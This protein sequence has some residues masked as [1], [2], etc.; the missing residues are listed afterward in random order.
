MKKKPVILIICN[1]YLPGYK[2]GGGMRTIVNTVERLKDKFDFRIIT[3]NCD[4]DG[5]PYRNIKE[6]DWNRIGGAQVFYLPQKSA[7][8]SKI[9]ELINEVQP[10][11]VYLNSVFS[12]LTIKTLL[13]RKLSL[14]PPVKFILA[15]EG[16][17]SKGALQLKSEKK[18]VFLNAAKLTGL[19]KDLIWKTTSE[20]EEQESKK[21]KGRGGKIFIAPNLPSKILLEDYDQDL[22]PEKKTGE[23]KMVF[24]SRFMQKKNFNWLLP[25]LKKIEGNLTIDIYGNLEDA[26]YWMQAQELIKILPENIEIQY[27]GAIAYEKVVETLF[28]Y[29]FFILPTLGENFGH[30][31]IEA[32]A[33]GCPLITSDRTPWRDLEEKQIGWDIPLEKSQEWID[34]INYCINLGNKSYRE[35]STNARRYSCDWLADPK[36]EENTLRV[37]EYSLVKV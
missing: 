36:L 29:H 16:E 10:D 5:V 9:R 6:N 26:D 19:H 4:I 15:P 1:Y 11:S 3:F 2:S 24:L 12:I 30:V 32:L 25:L 13:L 14:I 7:K 17:L 21:I 28:Q 34:K 18:R 31:F 27:K 37:L 22:K 33:A 23:A 8:I 20:F 35:F